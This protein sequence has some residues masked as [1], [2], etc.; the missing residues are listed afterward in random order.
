VKWQSQLELLLSGVMHPGIS[1]YIFTG[2][3]V[4]IRISVSEWKRNPIITKKKLVGK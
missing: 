4:K 3:V 1:Q 2:H